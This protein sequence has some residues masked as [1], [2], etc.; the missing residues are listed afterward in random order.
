M[1]K[2]HILDV[3]YFVIKTISKLEEVTNDFPCHVKSFGYNKLILTTPARK[4]PCIVHSELVSVSLTVRDR[5]TIV[6]SLLPLVRKI[7][8]TKSENFVFSVQ[9]KMLCGQAGR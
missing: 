8:I 7:F 6:F 4:C 9:T 1:P 2:R 3:K 5:I